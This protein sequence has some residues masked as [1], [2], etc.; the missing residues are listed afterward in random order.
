MYFFLNISVKSNVEMFLFSENLQIS[1]EIGRDSRSGNGLAI[2]VQC[3][4]CG[5]CKLKDL[6]YV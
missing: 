1:E 6:V 3:Y 2:I 5:F 4:G